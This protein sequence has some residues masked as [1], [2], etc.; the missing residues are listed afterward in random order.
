MKLI[1]DANIVFSGILNTNSRIGDLLI[2]SKQYFTFIAPHFLTEEIRNHYS[3]LSKI[4]GL[5][6]AQ[7]QEA[8]IHICKNLLFISEEQI[9]NA[10]W[11][12]ASILVADVDLKD[13]T[14]VAFSKHF[15]CSIWSGDKA[16][17]KG[18]EKKGFKNFISTQELFK[19]REQKLK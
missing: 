14:Y 17:I 19:L 5:T 3:K 10:C 12:S 8:E 4:S 7:I 18:L 16:L 2:N 1:V 15:H 13:T 6:L 9:K 11:I